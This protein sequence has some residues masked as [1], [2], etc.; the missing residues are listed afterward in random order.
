MLVNIASHCMSESFELRCDNFDLLRW[1]ININ[2]KAG[3]L[4]IFD[5]KF[6]QTLL[7]RVLRVHEV[8]NFVAQTLRL[9]L[10]VSF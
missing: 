10:V 2:R 8:D 6:L 3:F 9:H 1:E 7:D 4:A 5:A